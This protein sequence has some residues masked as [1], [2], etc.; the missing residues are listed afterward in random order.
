MPYLSGDDDTEQ[1]ANEQL[2][3]TIGSVL[4]GSI[5]QCAPLAAERQGRNL[6]SQSCGTGV[7]Q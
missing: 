2:Q 1:P 3:P 6:P 5:V 4:G 7:V